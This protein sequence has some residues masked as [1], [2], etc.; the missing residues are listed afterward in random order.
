MGLA[1]QALRRYIY[2]ILFY[3][4]F[5]L[6]IWSKPKA[7]QRLRRKKKFL[8]KESLL[9]QP[10]TEWVSAL[11]GLSSSCPISCSLDQIF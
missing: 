9:S 5:I 8:L 10:W 11:C 3:V 4:N 2:A 7:K 1:P 6:K